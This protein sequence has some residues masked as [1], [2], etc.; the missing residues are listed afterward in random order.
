MQATTLLL[1]FFSLIAFSKGCNRTLVVHPHQ[2]KLVTSPNHPGFYPNGN[3]CVTFI[4]TSSPHLCLKFT[5]LFLDVEAEHQCRYDRVELKTDG[6]VVRVY[7]GRFGD[8]NAHDRMTSTGRSQ[9]QICFTTDTTVEGAGFS[10]RAEADICPGYNKCGSTLLERSG[11]ITSRN[12]PRQ[13]ENDLNCL[14]HIRLPRLCQITLCF[15]YFELEHNH[16]CNFD[17]VDIYNGSALVPEKR[18]GRYCHLHHHCFH[19]GNEV[20]IHFKTDGSIV[21]RGFRLEYTSSCGGCMSNP[22]MNGGTCT[23]LPM[24][25]YMCVCPFGFTGRSCQSEFA[26]IINRLTA[27]GYLQSPNYPNVYPNDYL[28]DFIITAKEGKRVI[29]TIVDFHLERTD[30]CQN[31]RLEIYDGATSNAN[32]VGFFCGNMRSQTIQSTSNVMILRFISNGRMA[33]SGFL[34][35]YSS[36]SSLPSPP[37]LKRNGGCQQVC[38]A[39]SANRRRCSCRA[40]FVIN[41]DGMTC[42]DIDECNPNLNSSV[43]HRCI[44]PAVCQ[45]TAGSYYCQCTKPGF[46][47]ALEGRSCEDEN[48]CENGAVHHCE[49]NCVNTDGSYYCT[50]K[51]GYILSANGKQCEDVDECLSNRGGCDQRCR[52]LPGSYECYCKKG[53]IVNSENPRQCIDE[54]ECRYF[55]PSSEQCPECRTTNSGWYKCKCPEHFRMASPTDPDDVRGCID[56]DECTLLPTFCGDNGTCVNT[57]GGVHCQC[58]SGFTGSEQFR[59]VDINEC[60]I[61]DGGCQGSCHNEIGSFSCSCPVGYELAQDDKRSC[62]DINECA[63]SSVCDQTCL[64]V[65]GSYH[66]QCRV[67]FTLSS[68]PRSCID[69]NECELGTDNCS[70]L[71]E[72]RQGSYSCLCPPGYRLSIDQH[73]CIDVDECETNNGRCQQKCVNTPGNFS[74]QCRRGY[75][76]EDGGISCQDVNECEQSPCNMTCQN[77]NGSFFC[78]CPRPRFVLAENGVDC[79]D[80]DE[81]AVNNGGCSQVCTNTYGGHDCSCFDG[82]HPKGRNSPKCK[83]VNECKRT[84]ENNCSQTCHNT[85][86][87][88]YCSC[89]P[90]YELDSDNRTCIDVDE[91]SLNTTGCSQICTNVDGGFRCSCLVGFE[92]SRNNFRKCEDVNECMQSNGNCSGECVNTFGS[93]ECQCKDNERL[94]EDRLSCSACPTCNEYNEMRTK[95][96]ILQEQIEHLQGQIHDLQVALLQSTAKSERREEVD[97]KAS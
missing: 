69:V 96:S 45:N 77:T 95:M 72:N 47:L 42:R 37:C 26:R 68:D 40:G 91:C 43:Q 25:S 81:C 32:R 97:G 7:C 18:V 3:H 1:I 83:D 49:Q 21:K 78:E 80:V 85:E 65:N 60:E 79:L 16:G 63:N 12:Y 33:K 23:E 76:S 87:S 41:E 57:V 54:D 64:N 29:L 38:T 10:I 14:T 9:A 66:C 24:D 89:R 13:Y 53:F 5:L 59:C 2:P 58:K 44:H 84:E 51:D 27:P 73:Q 39:L 71:C 8:V 55:S 50:C 4:S 31:D 35:Y 22:C 92:V 20:L 70:N 61:D 11:V 86:G 67:G 93:Y 36:E 28:S 82:F 88:Y 15:T 17:F 34:I 46:K 90:G 62:L 75:F 52:N 48:E 19:L 6:D 74:C 94:G 30:N 56:I